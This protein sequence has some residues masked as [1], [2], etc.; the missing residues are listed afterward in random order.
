MIP[1][2]LYSSGRGITL[3]EEKL[4]R[5]IGL[6][7]Q[8]TNNRMSSMTLDKSFAE[9]VKQN[10]LTN[11]KSTKDMHDSN[12]LPD[13]SRENE[14]NW[15]QPNKTA[16]KRRIEVSTL[17]TTSLSN[18]FDSLQSL[19]SENNMD[20]EN[21]ENNQPEKIIKPPPI[22]TH[23]VKMKTLIDTMKE[24]IQPDKFK[25]KNN[26]DN[27]HIIYALDMQV[28]NKIKLLLTEK[29]INFYT[30][31]PKQEKKK[32]IVLKGINAEYTDNEIK[33]E[34]TALKIDNVTIIKVEKMKFR[35][36]N[37]DFL[38]R[39]YI[40]QLS[41]DSDLSALTKT[42]TLLQQVIYWQPLRRSKVFQCYKCQRVG[43][44]SSNCVLKS[45]CVKCAETHGKGECLLKEKVNEN[46]KCA[47]C[48]QAHPA[49]YRGCPY[50]LFAEEKIKENN[51]TK[52]V[53]VNQR[54]FKIQNHVSPRNTYA[55][56]ANKFNDPSNSYNH[57]NQ[58]SYF[59]NHHNTNTYQDNNE[60]LLSIKNDIINAFD[61]RFNSMKAQVD[62]N[63]RNI[64]R[65]LN[66]LNIGNG[67]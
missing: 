45:R 64:N 12:S 27:N 8:R 4:S 51:A 57:N 30:Y 25:I 15:S 10:R 33:E 29:S 28:Y 21:A 44:A 19:E 61:L 53:K 49:S 17:N 56:V 23:N 48:G 11:N 60:F 35:N 58:Q 5:D 32:S 65:V 50:L 47:N 34:L 66:F 3:N 41:N 52:S 24:K 36:K 26:A 63:S 62:N 2:P 37:D 7:G 22:N 31:T 39:N 13:L 18:K 16:K 55:Q 1:R 6:R 20:V 42:R 46:V 67:Y 38:H 14:E 43:H 59:N 40:V 54:L 9:F